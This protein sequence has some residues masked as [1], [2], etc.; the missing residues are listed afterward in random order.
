MFTGSSKITNIHYSTLRI[1]TF[2]AWL[3]SIEKKIPKRLLLVIVTNR[4]YAQSNTLNYL[5]QQRN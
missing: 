1:S 5:R 3:N 4:E 2:L